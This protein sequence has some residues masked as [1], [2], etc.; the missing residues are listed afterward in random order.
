MGGSLAGSSPAETMAL[1]SVVSGKYTTPKD[2]ATGVRT[3][4][5]Q[6]GLSGLK[7]KGIMGAASQLQAMPDAQRKAF[8][9]DNK[10]VNTAYSFIVEQRAV[11]ARRQKEIDQ[12][13][14]AT[15]TGSSYIL[16]ATAAMTSPTTEAG[17]INAARMQAKQAAVAQEIGRES[18]FAV[19]GFENQMTIQRIQ[20]QMEQR[21]NN[22]VARYLYTH[23][24]EA[25]QTMG[26]PNS[27]TQSAVKLGALFDWVPLANKAMAGLSQVADKMNQA[28]RPDNRAEQRARVAEPTE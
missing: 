1:L 15:G 8:L 23:G 9:K 22:P 14:S 12:V 27:V 16:Q 5:Q 4:G 19:R 3:F 10:E 18:Q 2:A 25:A 17:R 26:V 11:I 20:T 13:I 7:G 6:V 24:A 28:A 21:H